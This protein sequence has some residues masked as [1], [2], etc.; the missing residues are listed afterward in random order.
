[1]LVS[2]RA[3]AGASNPEPGS[4]SERDPVVTSGPDTLPERVVEPAA[5]VP[6]APLVMPE[7][8]EIA[9]PAAG[10]SRN[11]FED[12][13]DDEGV[14]SFE[15]PPFPHDELPAFAVPETAPD[16]WRVDPET[17]ERI[18]EGPIE[19][20][21]DGAVGPP[22][23]RAS[24]GS[25][26]IGIAVVVAVVAF[27]ALLAFRLRSPSPD[28]APG[29]GETARPADDA[30]PIGSAPSTATTAPPQPEPPPDPEP[31]PQAVAAPSNAAPSEAAPPEA[32]PTVAAV[33][34]ATPS[35]APHA[36]PATP[37]PAAPADD[38]GS[39]QARLDAGDVEGAGAI[40][41][42]MV[43]AS[44]RDALALQVLI[45]CETENI[46]KARH[47]TRPDGPLFVVPF[48]LQGRS[49]WR[50]CWGRYGDRESA[51]AAAAA[52]PSY[53]TTAGLTPVVVSFGRLR[54][55]G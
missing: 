43:A 53:F 36:Q 39:G 20:T 11:D 4:N 50:V 34:E 15:P 7:A 30:A 26:W 13:R 37:E 8:G 51:R 45:A 55:P 28:E 17:G 18:H 1:V 2:A 38:L 47:V 14:E 19:M 6:P 10:A 5:P 46:L 44:P 29:G 52:L 16:G 27:A 42:R 12:E 22:S 48:R 32:P 33:P 40:F 25:R 54:P 9:R 31:T 24:T 49:C 23:Q 41:T 3:V 21:F 35:E